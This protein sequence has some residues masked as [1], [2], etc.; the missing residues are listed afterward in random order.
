MTMLVKRL[1]GLAAIVGAVC[2]V[3]RA[4]PRNTRES[5]GMRALVSTFVVAG[6][7]LRVLPSFLSHLLRDGRS[8]GSLLKYC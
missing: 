2:L 3:W 5:L 4:L 6:R 7:L 8:I 1:V